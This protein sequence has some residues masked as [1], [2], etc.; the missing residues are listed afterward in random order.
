LLALLSSTE[1]EGALPGYRGH[2][3][4]PMDARWLRGGWTSHFVWKA[5]DTEA[6][7]DI[8]GAAPRASSPWDAEFSGL[9]AGQHTV[10]EMKR[11]DREKDWPFATA[12]GV[13]LLEAGDER[14]W[15]HIFN[16]EA[17]VGVAERLS[18]PAKLVHRRPALALLAAKD[19]RL[20]MALKA[21]VEFW[22]RLD[23]VRMH[24]Y[25]RAVRP[26]MLAVKQDA[27][28][29][30][31]QLPVQHAARVEHAERLLAQN[32]LR[33]YG[34][35]RLVA[36]AREQAARFV[37]PGSLEWLPDARGSFIGLGL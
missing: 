12:L 36:E 28:S 5:G 4:P 26:Y 27:R 30:A 7:L 6:Y 14:G 10:A 25:E 24:V 17:L 15:L 2:I 9:Y 31:P 20:E 16:Y 18:C 1:F 29:D 13:K 21:E 37:P 3:T 8:F 23:K 35:A 11:T 33:D 19:E 34:L 22:H 32:P